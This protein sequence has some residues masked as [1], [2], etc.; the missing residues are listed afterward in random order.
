[1]LLIKHWKYNN[2]S[3]LLRSR[4]L[5]W[6]VM[7]KYEKR[8]T[9]KNLRIVDHSLFKTLKINLLPMAVDW[10]PEMLWLETREIN[11][12]KNTSNNS[13]IVYD[14]YFKSLEIKLLEVVIWDEENKYEINTS[15]NL[16]TVDIASCKTLEME[17]LPMA[18]DW[19]TEK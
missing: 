19:W 6:N 5:W 1:M 11:M 13:T 2:C 4:K 16:R 15:I 14:A 18:V 8:K 17:L 10:W 12:R 9:N 3:W 7:W